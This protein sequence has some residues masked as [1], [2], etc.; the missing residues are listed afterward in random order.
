MDLEYTNAQKRDIGVVQRGTLDMAFGIDENNFELTVPKWVNIDINAFIYFANTEYGGI[1]DGISAATNDIEKKYYGRTWHGIL[2]SKIIEPEQYCDYRT[3][4]GEANQVIQQIINLI[5]LGGFFVASTD[6][7]G[8]EIVNF[9]VDRYSTAYMTLLK[10]L[11]SV[12]ARLDVKFIK[13]KVVLSAVLVQEY[14]SADEL[15]IQYCNVGIKK[16]ELACNHLI[17]LGAG[18]LKDRNVIHL[19]TDENGGVLPYTTTD[20]PVQDSD[21]I[22]ST[23]NQ[24]IFGL[25]EKVDIYDYVN[26]STKENYIPMYNQ[27]ADWFTNYADYYQYREDDPSRFESVPSVTNE[28]LQLLTSQPEDWDTNYGSYCDAEQQSVMM[29]ESEAYVQLSSQPEDWNQ[30]YGTYYYFY[31]DGT[32]SG[33]EYRSVSGVTTY[34][35]AIQTR[36]P[37]DWETNFE[38]YYTDKALKHKVKA[39]APT[40]AKNKYYTDNKSVYVPLTSKP[41]DWST[42]Y[43]KYYTYEPKTKRY[44][45]VKGDKAP[46]WKKDTY[47]LKQDTKYVL[48]KSKPSDWSTHYDDYYT[49]DSKNKRYSAVTSN[50]AP[51]WKAKAYYTSHSITNPPKFK[52]NY[53]YAHITYSGAPPFAPNVYYKKYTYESAPAFMPGQIF[54]TVLDRYAELVEGGINRINE[55]NNRDELNSSVDIDIEYGIG[56]RLQG[57]I[58]DLEISVSKEIVKKIIKIENGS[59]PLIEYEL[60]EIV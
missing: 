40:W 44:S 26:A 55:L 3:L 25:D 33:T 18:E 30:N 56:D 27:P 43:K 45:A 34:K 24:Q 23:E 6:D 2:N 54:T 15:D 60:G 21:Y 36:K 4:Y 35:A 31:S 39:A 42:H 1:V 10:C 58:D 12:G 48:Q 51:K 22:L 9:Q 41:S 20:Y 49:Y 11:K 14:S 16:M 59:R 38:S 28:G 29:V 13:G 53:Y 37:T 7:S 8:L 32:A 50:I 47:Y 52:K 46:D 17:C 19:F 57:A 5:G